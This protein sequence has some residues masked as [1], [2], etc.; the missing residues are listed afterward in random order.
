MTEDIVG[1]GF[2]QESVAGVQRMYRD[3]LGGRLFNSSPTVAGQSAPIETYYGK[4]TNPPS[5]SGSG[6]GTGSSGSG[7]APGATGS[8][9][10]YATDGTDEG[11]TV[12]CYNP[13]TITIPLNTSVSLTR[14]PFTGNYVCGLIAGLTD[15]MVTGSSPDT[16]GYYS[17]T[18]GG[19]TV[20]VKNVNGYKLASGYYVLGTP[21]GTDGTTPA[22]QTNMG[23]FTGTNTRTR[24]TSVTC[25]GGVLTVVYSTDTDTYVNGMLITSTST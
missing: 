21:M 16:N 6:T 23:G 4:I 9:E 5:S 22:Y 15:I 12:I 17:G 11:F 10:I 19:I 7:I 18:A 25:S 8:A 24:A 14:D 13:S 2:D 1:Y 20:G 3:Y